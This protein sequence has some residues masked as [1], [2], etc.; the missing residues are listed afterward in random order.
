MTLL[1]RFALLPLL[2]F[3]SFAQPADPASMQALVSE[4][5][6][7]RMAVERVASAVTRIQ[8]TM[9]RLQMQEQKVARLSD[10]TSQ[11]R[12]D[13][14]RTSSE[15]AQLA[16]ALRSSES[17]LAHEQDQ[18]RRKVLE[19]QLGAMKGAIERNARNEQLLRAQEA[20]VAG[21]LRAEQARLDDLNDRLATVEKALES[22]G[23]QR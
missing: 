10:L 13:L 22:P 15:S 1:L 17:R 2:A 8:I 7:L 3:P 19:D 14:T 18:A 20:E 21:N 11:V 12:R 9:Q 4:M 23:T 16:E 5:R 6:Q